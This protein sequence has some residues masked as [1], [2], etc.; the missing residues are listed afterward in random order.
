AWGRRPDGQTLELNLGPPA[1][2]CNRA[3]ESLANTLL[4]Q[5]ADELD[6]AA[7]RQDEALAKH[8]RQLVDR[9]SSSDKRKQSIAFFLRGTADLIASADASARESLGRAINDDLPST[10]E[11]MARKNLEAAQ[12][13]KET[14][15]AEEASSTQPKHTVVV[16]LPDTPAE[17]EKKLAEAATA[18]VG[19]LASAS[20]LPLKTELFRRAEDAKTFIAA[21][22]EQV[23]VV[24]ANPEFIPRD[25]APRFAF[26]HEGRTTYE[27]KVVVPIHSKAKSLADLKGKTISAVDALGD[28]GV[29]VTTR[30]ADDLTALANALYGRTD[31]ALVSESNPLLAEHAKE[32]RV[33]H[34]TSPQ[35]QPVVAFAAMPSTDRTALDDALR[36]LPRTTLAPLQFSGVV[37]INAEPRVV[38]KHEIQTPPASSLGLKLDPP[39]AVPLRV[40]VELPR[41][42]IPEDLFGPP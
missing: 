16:F 33:I 28:D 14:A 38:A 6:R 25:F 24:I 8:A 9:A 39:I 34:T 30:V 17:T 13:Q 7:K 12:Q 26:S 27:R 23:G 4:A 15:L 41:V 10:I 1:D 29:A 35:P 37:R 42:E 20:S 2:V 36:S 18:I 3:K 31:A 32:L 19:N 21:H 40:S 22:R 11:T 5:A